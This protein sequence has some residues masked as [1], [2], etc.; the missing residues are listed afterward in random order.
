MFNGFSSIYA[1]EQAC[2]NLGFTTKRDNFV[3]RW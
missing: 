2:L 3:K 1:Y